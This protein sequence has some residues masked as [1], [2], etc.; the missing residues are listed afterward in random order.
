MAWFI[1][2]S[3]SHA[4]ISVVPYSGKLS[5]EKTFANCSL[6]PR[7]RMP[8]PQ[9][10]RRKLLRIAP[11]PRNLQNVSPSKVSRS[12]VSL[13]ILQ[14]FQHCSVSLNCVPRRGC[15]FTRE[16]VGGVAIDWD[17]VTKL[18]IPNFFLEVFVGHSRKFMLTKISCYMVYVCM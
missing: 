12:T 15:H 17:L 8:R 1:T 18:K 14:S 3:Y 9:I 16:I 13:F 4:L 6:L 5:R 10:S 2:N 7:Q 11:K